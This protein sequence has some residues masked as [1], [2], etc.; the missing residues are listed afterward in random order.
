MGRPPVPSGFTCYHCGSD[1]TCKAGLTSNG[2]RRFK[3]R[4]CKKAFREDPLRTGPGKTRVPAELPSESHMILELQ[5]IYQ[6]TGKPPTTDLISKLAKENKAYKLNLYYAVFG[7]FLT[8][9]KR[10]RIKSRY[11][12]EFD[13]E[14]RL[15]LLNQLRRLSQK[16]DRPLFAEDVAAA[17]KRKEVSPLNHF[18]TAFGTI[19]TAIEL[20]GV[21][22]KRVYTREE[23]IEH[24]RKVDAR[25]DRT[26]TGRDLDVLHRMGQGPSHRQYQRMFGTMSKARR[27]AAVK[28]TYATAIHSDNYWKRYTVAEIIGQL[29]TLGKQLGRKPTDRDINAASGDF[30]FAS[31]STVAKMFGSLPNAYRAAGFDLARRPQYSDEEIVAALK[32]LRNE[33]DRYPT[34]QDVNTASK[35]GKCPGANTVRKRL[36]NLKDIRSQIESS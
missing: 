11:L 19:P 15:L 14:D 5:A 21:A 3:C 12:Q 28:N 10:A 9:L 29:Q 1:R 36:G 35:A 30:T 23:L 32:R 4:S 27:A 31:A 26:V 24:L 13:E 33:L 20:A 2:K 17:R 34:Y 25:A 18:F 22:P 8:A 16:L 7:S 6:R